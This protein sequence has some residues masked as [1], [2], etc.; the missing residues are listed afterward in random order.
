I[1]DKAW[2]LGEV[3]YTETPSNLTKTFNFNCDYNGTVTVNFTYA[4]YLEDGDYV[5]VEGWDGTGWV[6]I[7]K[8][9]I[10]N[11]TCTPTPVSR[12]FSMNTSG[13]WDYTQIRFRFVSDGDENVS[14]GIYIY[15]VGIS[16]ATV[17]TGCVE[18]VP[19]YYESACECLS[20]YIDIPLNG[21]VNVTV[22][23]VYGDPQTGGYQKTYASLNIVFD[24]LNPQI[25]WSESD[26]SIIFTVV[27]TLSGVEA[28][29]DDEPIIVDDQSWETRHWEQKAGGKYYYYV[30]DLIAPS[31][32]VNSAAIFFEKIGLGY[33]DEL[34]VYGG[35][36]DCKVFYACR[37]LG[38]YYRDWGDY[39]YHC[40]WC[41]FGGKLWVRVPMESCEISEEEFCGLTCEDCGSVVFYDN[42]NDTQYGVR[43]GTIVYG[44]GIKVFLGG[45]DITSSVTI[46]PID[47]KNVT[48]TVPK[49]LFTSEEKELKVVVTDKVGNANMLSIKVKAEGE[50]GGAVG[51]PWEVYDANDDGAISDDELLN[52]IM[53]WLDNKIGDEELLNVIMKW[54]S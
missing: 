43:I 2:G 25:S 12:N 6:E 49:S 11:N 45:E 35:C 4:G 37:Y 33:E 26:D 30:F 1:F 20:D 39:E 42:N 8:L 22:E 5:V 7:T 34:Y 18:Y 50:G 52:A 17:C 36:D 15:D 27:D 53:G 54:L 3:N 21:T 9:D 14:A 47:E 24:N 28:N 31:K 40:P 32:A 13:S 41:E 51:E 23:A 19:E 46:T 38:Y 44:T 29:A 48:I 16:A 10:T